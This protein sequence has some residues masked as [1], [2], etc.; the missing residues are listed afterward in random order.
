MVEATRTLPVYIKVLVYTWAHICRGQC[1]E[2]AGIA[3]GAGSSICAGIALGQ[4]YQTGSVDKI[5]VPT[6]LAIAE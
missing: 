1:S 4:A 2:S 6:W 3:G 5:I